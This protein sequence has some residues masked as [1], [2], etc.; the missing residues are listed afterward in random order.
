MF[1]CGAYKGVKPLT[2]RTAGGRPLAVVD[3]LNKTIHRV[4]EEGRRRW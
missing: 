2:H 4:K 3:K 1:A